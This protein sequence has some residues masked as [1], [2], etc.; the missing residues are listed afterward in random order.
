MNDTLYGMNAKGLFKKLKNGLVVDKWDLV[1]I[2]ENRETLIFRQQCEI[3]AL[4]GNIRYLEA[5]AYVSD[6][7]RK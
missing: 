5:Q 6:I 2:I 7:G 1:K 4:K 3:D